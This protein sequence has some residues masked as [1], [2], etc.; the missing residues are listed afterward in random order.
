MGC[1]SSSIYLDA[2]AIRAMLAAL[3]AWLRQWF[4]EM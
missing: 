4:S 3:L 2:D 1:V